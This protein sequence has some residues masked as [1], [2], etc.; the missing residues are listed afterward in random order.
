METPARQFERV[1]VALEEIAATEERLLTAKDYAAVVALQQRATPLVALMADYTGP[2]DV[3]L[4]QQIMAL[5]ARR[6]RSEEQLS[7]QI[8]SSRNELS[9]LQ[10]S[11]RRV[12][13]IGPVYG[14][15]SI[16]KQAGHLSARG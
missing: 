8:K 7:R 4:R 10:A 9:Q 6:T 11:E 14:D 16:R 15:S 12:A 2:T 1:L 13:Q 5:I 3:K